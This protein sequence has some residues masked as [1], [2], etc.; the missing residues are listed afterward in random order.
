MKTANA[1]SQQSKDPKHVSVCTHLVVRQSKRQN[2]NN[3]W[4][5]CAH[6]AILATGH[7]G[8][9]LGHSAMQQKNIQLL[10]TLLL[11]RQAHWGI[12]CLCNETSSIVLITL[13]KCIEETECARSW[14][15]ELPAG[16]EWIVVEGK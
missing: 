8:W 10:A 2:R 3:E 5:T 6:F 13:L 7:F 4:P 15:R 16:F 14:I 1:T 9:G 12:R 11:V